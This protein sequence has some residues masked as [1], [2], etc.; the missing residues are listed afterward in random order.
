MTR[1]LVVDDNDVNLAVLR[2]LLNG[3]GYEVEEAHHGEEALA[4]CSQTLPDLV[5][6][7]LLMPVMDGYTLLRRWKTDIRLRHIPFIIYTATYTAPQDQ[8][9][10]EDLGAD[11]YILKPAKPGMLIARVRAVLAQK[12]AGTVTTREPIEDVGLQL[13]EYNQVLVRKL[14]EK[15]LQLEQANR[16]LAERERLLRTIFDTEPECVLL[17]AFDGTIMMVNASGLA[18]LELDRLEQSN[19]LSIFPSVS[20][21]QRYALR[22]L[23]ASVFQGDSGKMQ[24][25]LNGLKGGQRWLELHAVP[26][27][28]AQGQIDSILGIGRDVTE[29]WKAELALQQAN[30]ALRQLSQRLLKVQEAERAAIARE[31][32]DEIGQA[33]TAIKFGAQWLARRTTGPELLKLDDCIAIADGALAQVRSIALELRPPQLDQLGLTA[34]LRDLTERMATSAGLEACF[35][36]DMHEVAPGYAQS[37]S[38]FRVAQ[39]ALTNVVRHAGGRRVTV[40]LHRRDG[41]LL[42]AVSD[43]GRGFDIGAAQVRAAKGASMGLL[44]MQER[45]NLAG[46]WLRIES[47]PGTGTR[48]EAGFPIDAPSESAE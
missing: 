46:G 3:Y 37:T 2:A 20:E 27:R 1:I 16:E 25:Q 33:L 18:M 13:R 47:H 6:S 34:A 14:E 21:P 15:M 22:E 5:I 26:L 30:A 9:L 23:V 42:V 12:G 4:R 31:L 7:D 48:V 11:A 24:F 40:E 41:E 43:D 17:L 38:A 29:R 45:V 35:L 39:E 8:K 32:H 44:G 10:A 19:P 28:N 36:A